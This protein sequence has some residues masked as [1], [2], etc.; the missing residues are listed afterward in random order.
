MVFIA[1]ELPLAG[2]EQV[3]EWPLE[4]FPEPSGIVYHPLRRTLFVVGDEGDIGEVDL[5]GNLLHIRNLGGDLEGVTCNPGDGRLYVVREGDEIIF[6]VD[7][8]QL[9]IRR[10]FTIDRT[11]DGNANFLERGGDGVEGVTFV[12][13]EKGGQFFVV[14]QYDP[15]AL[16]ELGISS[17]T[18]DDGFARAIIVHSATIGSPPLS[19]VV[20]DPKN[21]VFLVVSA[22]WRSAYVV[23]R[24][25]QRKRTVRLPG[26]M[27]EGLALLP[28]GSFVIA[29]DTGGLVRWKPT[30]DPFALTENLTNAGQNPV[31]TNTQNP[32]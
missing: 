14:N 22:L 27:Q 23:D 26:I 19:D 21:R 7:P 25:G 9:T 4:A 6:E 3:E 16:L 5:A 28:D 1:T 13:G 31:T 29:Q 15:P 30:A 18:D 10:R 20:W 12:A 24:E 2:G 8:Q 32:R 11:Y 17:L